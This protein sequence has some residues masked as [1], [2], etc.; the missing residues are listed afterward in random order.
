[1]PQ[2]RVRK[3]KILIAIPLYLHRGGSKLVALSIAEFFPNDDQYKAPK[4]VVA[5]HPIN[6]CLTLIHQT[7]TILN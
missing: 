7:Q 6:V 2:Q 1:V 5:I 3:Y 4:F